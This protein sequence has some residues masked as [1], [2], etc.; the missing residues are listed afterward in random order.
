MHRILVACLLALAF[1]CGG[2]VP[3]ASADAWPVDS[4][5]ILCYHDVRDHLLERPDSYTIETGQLALQFAWLR[6]NGYH[7]LRFEDVVAARHEHRPLPDKAV[8]LSFD[9][10]LES[11]YTHVYPLLMA[12]RYSAVVGLV[13]A[14]LAVPSAGQPSPEYPDATLTRGD[15]LQPAQIAEM[16]GSGLI[17]F[18]SHSFA[19]HRGILA[20]PQGNLE[21][22]ATTHEFAPNG[23]GYESDAAYARRVGADLSRSSEDIAR[24]SGVRPRI[25]IWPYGA[26]NATTDR[27]ASAAGMPYGMTL[28]LGLNT[29]DVPL[30]SL[31]R[32]LITHDFTTAALARVLEETTLPAPLRL[33]RVALDTVYD[34]DPLQQEANLS[35]LLDR[36]QALGV[37][38]VVLQAFADP[39]HDGRAQALYFP[40][41]LLPVRADLFNRVA[42]QLRT[43][44][45]VAVYGW[46]PVF[47]FALP[48][49]VPDRRAAIAAIYADF[50]QH[51]PI[52]GLLFSEDANSDDAADAT[53]FSL[54]LAADVRADHDGLRIARQLA[55]PGTV[56][57]LAGFTTRLGAMLP[58]Y[59]YVALAIGSDAPLAPLLAAVARLPQGLAKTVFELP[60]LDRSARDAPIDAGVLVT[61]MESLRRAGALSYGYYPDDLHAGRPPIEAL[62]PS[63]SLKSLPIDD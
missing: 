60:T 23:G 7:V 59:D 42:W 37:N 45:G 20:N 19:L 16:Q 57:D 58:A 46:L 15:F 4:F 56:T 1:A 27:L 14:W 40:N 5:A 63:L 51:A 52:Q 3:V 31:R 9:D 54:R 24:L 8:V 10:G 29:P 25:V 39:D 38:T 30:Q 33:I 34:A 50:S 6:E 53:A 62:R 18:A 11:I 21:P 48:Q 26:H 43:R 35:R 28:E 22:A 12:F 49:G 44:T 41:R 2:G 61:E 47:D 32:T 13:G 36:V 55:A 17:D